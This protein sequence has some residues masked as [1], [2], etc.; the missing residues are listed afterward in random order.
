MQQGSQN[1][2]TQGRTSSP[3]VSDSHFRQGLRPTC[4]ST[5][6]RPEGS[7]RAPQVPQPRG[8]HHHCPAQAFCSASRAQTACTNSLA[9]D[10]STRKS[11]PFRPLPH[12]QQGT[13]EAVPFLGH[14]HTAAQA[15]QGGSG[16]GT[17][18]QAT[19]G[20]TV[21]TMA[22]QKQHV[23]GAVDPHGAKL[24]FQMPPRSR[25]RLFSD[26][27]FLFQGEKKFVL[28]GQGYAQGVAPVPGQRP[29]AGHRQGPQG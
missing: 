22:L 9:E 26:S 3:P 2:S 11:L 24:V 1:T 12:L 19:W 28:P 10:P 20:P 7:L 25:T 29:P 18:T 6:R 5:R 21:P 16:C 23:H 15:C 8:Q 14:S 27:E 4:S 13:S 17:R